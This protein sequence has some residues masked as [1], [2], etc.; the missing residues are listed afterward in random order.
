MAGSKENLVERQNVY[1]DAIAVPVI[2][3]LADAFSCR[4]P[5]QAQGALK[6]MTEEGNG[7]AQYLFGKILRDDKRLLFWE[8]QEFNEGNYTNSGS[9]PLRLEMPLP[10]H[11]LFLNTAII[12]VYQRR[13]CVWWE[14]AIECVD[15]PEAACNVGVAYALNAPLAFSNY[16]G[17]LWKSCGVLMHKQTSVYCNSGRYL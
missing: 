13:V 8:S 3:N 7:M 15:L 12:G 14:R 6:K 16:S 1:E 10:W 9:Y 2:L 4:S 17:E 5:T 11:G